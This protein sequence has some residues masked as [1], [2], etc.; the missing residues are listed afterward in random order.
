[1]TL[2]VTRGAKSKCNFDLA[3]DLWSTEVDSGQLNQVISNL[4]LNAIQA[5]PTGGIITIRSENRM[6][7]TDKRNKTNSEAKVIVSSGY[8]NDPIMR[9]ST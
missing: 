2:F 7:D 8:S 4:V 1:M 6:I 5:M 9:I 3:S